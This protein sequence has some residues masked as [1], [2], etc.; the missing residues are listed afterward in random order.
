M[1]LF[2][3]VRKLIK[4]LQISQDKFADSIGL[5]QSTLNGYLK[6]N[7]QDNLWPLLHKIIEVYPEINRD[8]LFHDEE[9]VFLC[10]KPKDMEQGERLRLHPDIPDDPLGRISFLTGRRTTSASILAEL[11]GQDMKLMK[12]FLAKYLVDRREREKWIASGANDEEYP[13]IGSLY[14]PREWLEHFCK[15]HVFN[16]S[17]IQYGEHGGPVPLLLP[18]ETVSHIE[19]LVAELRALRETVSELAG[20]INA[21]EDINTSEE[22]MQKSLVAAQG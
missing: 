13:K 17:W 4:L 12:S 1:E 19:N 11:F 6:K 9:P 10:D 18:R 8:W 21:P 20:H 5:H 22:K 14:L 3:R 16:W 7:R 2:E 15:N